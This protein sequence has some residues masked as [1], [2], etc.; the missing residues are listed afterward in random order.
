MLN[1]EI[2]KKKNFRFPGKKLIRNIFRE[3]RV[4]NLKHCQYVYLIDNMVTDHNKKNILS[5]PKPLK[6]CQNT[7]LFNNCWYQKN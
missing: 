5:K 6:Q 4:W 7:C 1:S 3:K 2:L